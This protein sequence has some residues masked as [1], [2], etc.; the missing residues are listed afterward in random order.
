MSL[1]RIFHHR[2]TVRCGDGEDGVQIDRLAKEVDWHDS[3]GTGRDGGLQQGRI[4]QVAVRI[5]IHKNGLG[6]AKRDRLTGGDERGRHRDNLIARPDP[7]GEQG[8]P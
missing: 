5:N 2:Q 8:H 3:L 6:P 1:C 4:H 7:E